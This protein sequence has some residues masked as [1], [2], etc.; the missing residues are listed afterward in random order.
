VKRLDLLL[1]VRNLRFGPLPNLSACR[2]W[3]EAKREKLI[4]LRE[5]ESQGLRLSDEAQ[6][7]DGSGRE[8]SISGIGSRRFWQKTTPFVVADG[9]NFSLHIHRLNPGPWSGVKDDYADLSS[10]SEV[11]DCRSNET[12]HRAGEVPAIRWLSFHEPQ[13]AKRSCDIHSPI[14]GV[15][16]PRVGHRMKREQP[17]EQSETRRRHDRPPCGFVV[18]QP[19][20]YGIAPENFCQGSHEIEQKRLHLLS[21]QTTSEFRAFFEFWYLHTFTGFRCI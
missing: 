8:C 9:V 4:Y 18:S 21:L 3:A 10:G 2:A 1:K 12:N 20:E 11:N 13:P 19:Q 17:C 14:G 5:R 15:Y 16:P 7:F 6:P